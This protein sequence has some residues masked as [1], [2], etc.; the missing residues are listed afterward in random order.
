VASAGAVGTLLGGVMVD[1]MAASD[2]DPVVATCRGIVWT[3]AGGSACLLG[4]VWAG[5][6]VFLSL[7]TLGCCLIF[8]STPGINMVS[9]SVVPKENEAFAMGILVRHILFPALRN[10]P[11][12]SHPRPFLPR[13]SA[14]TSSGTSPCPSSSAP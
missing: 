12:F 9:M 4:A 7:L 5:K 6:E 13:P 2:A 8:M 3:I 14:F 11:L 1:K 10:R